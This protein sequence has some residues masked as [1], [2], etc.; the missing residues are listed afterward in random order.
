MKTLTGG[1]SH[2]QTDRHRNSVKE[3]KIQRQTYRQTYITSIYTCIQRERIR[4][5]DTDKQTDRQ[6]VH[7]YIHHRGMMY[8][9]TDGQTDRPK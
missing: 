7:K 6:T 9:L 2:I 3:I 5:K 4:D 8:T 1:H